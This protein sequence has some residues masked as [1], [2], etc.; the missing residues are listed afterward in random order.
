MT[1]LALGSSNLILR[2]DGDF[3]IIPKSAEFEQ[4]YI[5]A[6]VKL[7]SIRVTERIRD[8]ILLAMDANVKYVQIDK[9]TLMLNTIADISPLP[10]K[11]GKNDKALTLS[12]KLAEE[13]GLGRQSR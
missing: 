7:P 6:R 12:R 9:I 8:Q 4:N 10:I 2:R 11:K 3:Q 13:Q 1:K 5:I